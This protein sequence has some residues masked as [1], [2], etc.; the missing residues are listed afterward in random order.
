M[1]HAHVRNIFPIFTHSPLDILYSA[2]ASALEF[3]GFEAILI[4]YPLIKKGKSLNKWAHGGIVFTTILYVILALVSL[5]YY[6]QGQLHHTIWPT[7]TMLKIIKVP[8]I[9]R[10]E[11][12][13]IFIWFL[14]ILPNL[15]LTIWSS[16]CIT[17]KSFRIPFNITLPFFITT[18]FISS[19]FFTKP[20]K[21]QYIKYRTISGWIVYCIRLYPNLISIP[22]TTMALQKSVEKIFTRHTIISDTILLIH[23]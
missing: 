20:R 15:C 22:F 14:I 5:M 17:K 7:L 18:I 9:Q 19:L 23:L 1:K 10:F 4:F 11:Y 21:Y 6:S 16:C 2:K 13:I 3:L 12:I 8:F